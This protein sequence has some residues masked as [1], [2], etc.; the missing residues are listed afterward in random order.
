[1]KLT[2]ISDIFATISGAVDPVTMYARI[3]EQLT[4]MERAGRYPSDWVIK[5]IQRAADRRYIELIGG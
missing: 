2:T 4:E 1:M 5:G 3:R